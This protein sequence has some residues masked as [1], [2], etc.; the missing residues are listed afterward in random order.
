[1]TIEIL[2]I[3]NVKKIPNEENAYVVDLHIKTNN[4]IELIKYTARPGDGDISDQI[5]RE[6]KKNNFNGLI[7]E[8]EQP[9]N[10]EE[11][12]IE[13]SEI[14]KSMTK[15]EKIDLI[16]ASDNNIELRIFL[17]DLNNFRIINVLDEDFQKNLLIIKD[18]NIL[19]S[20]R[21]KEIFK[22]NI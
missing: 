6:I 4:E 8:L 20:N 21:I 10:F 11:L 2:N 14:K 15:Q 13:V 19:S 5:I 9:E 7:G 12:L 16:V 17:E 18:L 3:F 1:M 22:T